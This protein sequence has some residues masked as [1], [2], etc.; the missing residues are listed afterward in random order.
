[1]HVL[2]PTESATSEGPHHLHTGPGGSEGGSEGGGQRLAAV[3][4]TLQELRSSLERM[5]SESVD[6][7]VKAVEKALDEKLAEIVSSGSTGQ[8]ISSSYPHGT[9]VP[10]GAHLL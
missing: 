5:H 8:N 1:M 2:M 3:E 10:F 6:Q 9:S 7:T 4:R